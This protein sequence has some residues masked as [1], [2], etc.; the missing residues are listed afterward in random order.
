MNPETGDSIRLKTL[1]PE[2]SRC[3]RQQPWTSQYD[4][5][6]LILCTGGLAI[7]T[8]P[9]THLLDILAEESLLSCSSR[10]MV[11]ECEIKPTTPPGHSASSMR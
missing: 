8:E 6:D 10:R 2:P 4:R 11:S 5:I 1:A 7:P 9:A 3:L